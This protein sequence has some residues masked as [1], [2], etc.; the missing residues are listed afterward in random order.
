ML[1]FKGFMFKD[2]DLASLHMNAVN[3]KKHSYKKI[4]LIKQVHTYS[5][6]RAILLSMMNLR[7]AFSTSIMASYFFKFI[8]QGPVDV[9]KLIPS[10]RIYILPQRMHDGGR[11][12]TSVYSTTSQLEK[13]LRK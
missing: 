2:I 8:C 4:H 10:V 12:G 6:Y 5:V 11:Q 7:W 9:E 1:L 3:I 13:R